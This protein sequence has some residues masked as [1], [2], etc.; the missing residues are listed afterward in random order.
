MLSIGSSTSASLTAAELALAKEVYAYQ[1]RGKLMA[2]HRDSNCEDE[3][4]E[5]NKALDALRRE[6]P[7]SEAYQKATGIIS[8][9]VNDFGRSVNCHTHGTTYSP[10]NNIPQ[11][12]PF[13]LPTSGY[14]FNAETNTI[15]LG[16]GSKI[17]I[18]GYVLEIL[19]NSVITSTH[20]GSQSAVALDSLLRGLG[21]DATWGY[22]SHSGK[23]TMDLLQKL[24]VDTSKPFFINGTQFE[25]QGD[26]LRTVGQTAKQDMQ[27]W[28]LE[29][30]NRLVARA[31][32]QNLL[33][34]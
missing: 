4:A 28:G 21:V 31:Y 16:I 20:Q 19:E 17:Q 27:F 11:I 22:D 7:P 15:T 6:G 25:V 2:A 13:K 33:V 3:K 23:I 10:I 24:G 34:G 32:E 9:D 1:Q 29:G 8:H 18:D 14:S 30:L 12:P 26:K 5:L